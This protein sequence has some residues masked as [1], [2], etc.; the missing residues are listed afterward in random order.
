MARKARAKRKN[1]GTGP[2]AQ[3][4]V[5]DSKMAS[6]I[7]LALGGD[8]ESIAVGEVIDAAVGDLELLY[9]VLSARDERVAAGS[10]HTIQ[11]RLRALS[12]LTRPICIELR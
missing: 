9:E 2:S 5:T 11:C 6:I 12:E 3:I 4:H 8:A 10:L 1:I 7:S